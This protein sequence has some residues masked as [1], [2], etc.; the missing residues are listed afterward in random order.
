MSSVTT[1]VHLVFLFFFSFLWRISPP[2][3]HAASLFRSL[4]S[5]KIGHSHTAGRTPLNEWSARRRDLYLH[6]THTPH[7]RRRS[8]PFGIRISDCSDRTTADLRLRPYGHQNRHHPVYFSTKSMLKVCHQLC[9]PSIHASANHSP[10]SP[11]ISSQN[12]FCLIG[13]H[14]QP[15]LRRNRLCIQDKLTHCC[16][17]LPLRSGSWLH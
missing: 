14:P 7:N 9:A 5:H 8:I 2:L 11:Q 4:W 17:K 12:R 15:F 13:I 16:C 1:A 10:S 3:V 6:I